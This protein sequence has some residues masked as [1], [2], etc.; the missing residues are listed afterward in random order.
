MT[1]RLTSRLLTFLAIAGI[2][3]ISV[4]QAGA[5]LAFNNYRLQ[6]PLPTTKMFDGLAVTVRPFD[7]TAADFPN[8]AADGFKWVRAD[9]AWSAVEYKKGVYDFN[10]YDAFVQ[11]CRSN[12][13]R[14]HFIFNGGNVFYT[15]GNGILPTTTGGI[16]GF[17]NFA[18]AAVNHYR[19]QGMM[20]EMLNEPDL[21]GLTPAQYVSLSR[22]V[23]QGIR[24][25][26]PY[27]WFIGPALSNI[28][29][30]VCLQY[31][32]A[33][34]Q[35]GVL[36]D[37]DAVTVHPYRA[38]AP[39]TV[40][41][42]YAYIR[43]LIAQ[44]APL[45]K[46][47]PLFAGEWGYE[48]DKLPFSVP[49]SAFTVGP[50]NLVT[51]PL[52]FSNSQTW[53]GYWA[54]PALQTGVPDPFGGYGATRLTSCDYPTNGMSGLVQK[55]PE[56]AGVYYTVSVWLRSN[57]G[58]MTVHMGIDDS[59]CLGFVIDGTWRRYSYTM[60]AVNKWSQN[61]IFQI[62]EWTTGNPDWDIYGPQV[63]MIGAP[64][65][66]LIQD[67]QLNLQGDYLRR[68]YLASIANNVPYC[69]LYEWKESTQTPYFGLNWADGTPKPAALDLQTM[70]ANYK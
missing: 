63:E 68:A 35:G 24:Q 48:S 40:G 55:G 14:V 20:W 30:T 51:S 69:C 60:M 57:G 11:Q 23:G 70:Y 37:Y 25:V 49:P 65:P 4:A 15:G 12:G 43:S 66:Q 42:D 62:S 45:G 3:A 54:K 26:S 50:P 31:F 39:E 7:L 6:N 36:N 47:I 53:M 56:I 59:A 9:L 61:R 17:V 67:A 21:S 13:L 18:K 16:T 64:T 44:Y 22:A 27:E 41:P 46:N 32:V 33:V 34:L 10:R 29:R 5:Q 8:I 52:D 1:H 28:N 38:D 58:P 2:W 19:Q